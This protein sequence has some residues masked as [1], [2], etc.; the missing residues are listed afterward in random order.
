MFNAQGIP[1][2]YIDR[3]TQM[4]SI[5]IPDDVYQQAATLAASDRGSVQNL[6][7]VL[8]KVSGAQP[9]AFDRLS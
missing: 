8:H 6:H 4:K 9:E 3:G 7:A 2:P 1:Y 5:H